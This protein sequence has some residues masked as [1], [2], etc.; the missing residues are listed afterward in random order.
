MSQSEKFTHQLGIIPEFRVASCTYQADCRDLTTGVPGGQVGLPKVPEKFMASITAVPSAK[1]GDKA[2]VE[3][4]FTELP[5]DVTAAL[6]KKCAAPLPSHLYEHPRLCCSVVGM[7][8]MSVRA[9]YPEH[10]AG[11]LSTQRSSLDPQ[12]RFRTFHW[13]SVHGKLQCI[14]AMALSKPRTTV[15]TGHRLG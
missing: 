1:A 2:R 10:V 12:Q 11:S 4:I 8:G 7:F 6:I 14:L 13:S 3:A 15:A 9:A 5:E